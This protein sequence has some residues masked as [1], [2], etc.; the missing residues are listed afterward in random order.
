MSL[1]P[2]DEAS[3]SQPSAFPVRKLKRS[4]ELDF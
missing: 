4:Q 1:D 2:N 3:L